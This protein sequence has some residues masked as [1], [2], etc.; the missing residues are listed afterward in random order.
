LGVGSG[1][2][3][4]PYTS[5]SRCTMRRSNRRMGC[6]AVRVGVALTYT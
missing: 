4:T 5:T 1:L 3:E 2:R 6:D